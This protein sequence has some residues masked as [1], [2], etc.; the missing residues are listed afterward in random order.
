MI[1]LQRNH[2]IFSVRDFEHMT[3]TGAVSEDETTI[4]V[5]ECILTPCFGRD[6]GNKDFVKPDPRSILFFDQSN[7]A[8]C[9]W[10]KF[11]NPNQTGYIRRQT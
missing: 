8:V 5:N 6:S 2:R 9:F 4:H 10:S 11:T 1:S 3:V 7:I